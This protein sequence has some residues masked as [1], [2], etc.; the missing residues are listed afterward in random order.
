M[1]DV[2]VKLLLSHDPSHWNKQVTT[3]HKILM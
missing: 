1:P 3:D 2:P